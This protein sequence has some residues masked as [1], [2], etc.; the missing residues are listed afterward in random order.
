MT[1]HG[2]M[3]Q[4]PVARGPAALLA[5]ALALAVAARARGHRSRSAWVA[6][7]HGLL[8]KGCAHQANQK[9]SLRDA[10]GCG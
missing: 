9:P 10:P 6:G 1:T 5:A 7:L 4:A 8:A 2:P 3:G